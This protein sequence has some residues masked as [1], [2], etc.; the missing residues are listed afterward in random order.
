M[1]QAAELTLMDHHDSRRDLPRARDSLASSNRPAP[2]LLA[3]P[4]PAA[5]RGETGQQ[6]TGNC[7][8]V[9]RQREG[10]LTASALQP[11]SVLASGN[12]L[13]FRECVQLSV[14]AVVAIA[15]VALLCPALL[16]LAAIAVEIVI[17]VLVD[18]GIPL[19]PAFAAGVVG[20]LLLRTLRRR[21]GG[22]PV[23]A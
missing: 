12:G 7:A 4:A 20:W 5:V 23:E 9:V 22:A 2:S 6:R 3:E 19:L 15:V 1:E 8:P 21:P 16:F 17:G 13:S 10:A 18:A 11:R 14:I